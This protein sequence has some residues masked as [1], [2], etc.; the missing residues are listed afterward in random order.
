VIY[1]FHVGSRSQDAAALPG[2][3]QSLKDQGYRFD[4]VA[5]LGA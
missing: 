1:L 4:T 2:M 5:D 3:I